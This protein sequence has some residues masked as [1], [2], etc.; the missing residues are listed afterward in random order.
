PENAL[1]VET[2]TIGLTIGAPSMY[3]VALESGKPFRM[4]R[5]MLTTLP[6]SHIGKTKPSKPLKSV[7]AV[8]FFGITLVSRSLETKTSTKPEIIEPRS[9]NGTPSKMT[10]RKLTAK[11][12]KLKRNQSIRTC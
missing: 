5:R 3:A 4:N 1:Q 11:S 8:G 10:L 12:G 6:H 9:R 7:A 2:A